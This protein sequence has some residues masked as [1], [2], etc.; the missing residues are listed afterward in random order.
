MTVHQVRWNW[1]INGQVVNNVQY[2]DIEDNTVAGRQE[3]V[4]TIRTLVD[5]QL[6][7]FLSNDVVLNS[8]SLRP[9]E[10]GDPFSFEVPFT[11]GV[12]V[13][14][15]LND[16]FD[17]TSPMQIY[18]R[19][20][21]DKPNRSWF[22]LSGLTESA[23]GGTGWN[24][25]TV[26]AVTDLFNFFTAGLSLSGGNAIQGICRPDFPSNTVTAFNLIS[27]VTVRNYT[28]KQTSRRPK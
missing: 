11:D 22:K 6:S 5:V 27:T 19:S 1:A 13:G 25:L 26:S 4:D 10:G 20:S 15:N 18:F 14:T 9:F 23:W 8:L 16:L 28:R 7:G 2:W 12:I 24:P 3:F 17:I 21:T